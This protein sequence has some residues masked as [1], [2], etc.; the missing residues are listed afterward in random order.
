M[1]ARANLEVT[2]KTLFG[3]LETIAQ[4]TE[5]LYPQ[6]MEEVEHPL[7]YLLYETEVEMDATITLA[8]DRC[9]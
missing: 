9:P 2:Q 6:S 1:L 7:G 3:N 4:V 8:R 5:T